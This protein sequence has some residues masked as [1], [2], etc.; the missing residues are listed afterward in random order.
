MFTTCL[1]LVPLLL[2][3]WFLLTMTN[4]RLRS[5]KIGLVSLILV[6][7]SN[8]SSLH[9]NSCRKSRLQTT[10]QLN[11]VDR[12]NK[13][14]LINKLTERFYL[15]FQRKA[16]ASRK[17]LQANKTNKQN[18]DVLIKLVFLLV[19]KYTMSTNQ[20]IYMAT[21]IWLLRKMGRVWKTKQYQ[22]RV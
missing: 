22:Q 21:R 10:Y 18:H 13:T 6:C 3:Y 11:R 20:K 12:P 14:R 17:F 9:V 1:W 4:L 5:S 15:N 2:W 8:P 7:G 16:L 19:E